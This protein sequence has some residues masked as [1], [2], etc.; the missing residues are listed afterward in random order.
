MDWRWLKRLAASGG[1]G[2]LRID[3][4]DIMPGMHQRLQAWHRKIRGSHKNNAHNLSQ[5]LGSSKRKP[6]SQ[7][8]GQS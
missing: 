4:K 3:G 1:A 7:V 6:L 5:A 2:R 8:Y